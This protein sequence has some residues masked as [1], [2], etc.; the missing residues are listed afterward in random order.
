[1]TDQSGRQE[2][3]AEQVSRSTVPKLLLPERFLLVSNRLPYRIHAD[4]DRVILQ[5][6]MGGL[7]TALDPVMRQVGGIWF[8]WSGSY[9]P[10]SARIPVDES[11]SG[12]RSYELCPLNLS[13][14][15]ISKYY[16]GH[17]NKCI[18]PLFHYFQEHCEY[19]DDNWKMYRNVNLKFAKKVIEEHREG[20]FVWIHDYQLL[21]VPQMIRREIPDAR[22]GFFL[23]IPFPAPEIFKIDIHAAEILEGL[24]GADLIGFHTMGYARNFIRSVA[25]LTEHRYSF[26]DDWIQIHDRLVR[27]GGFPIS[28]DTGHFERMA[29]RPG[30]D[31][32][33]REIRESYRADVLAIGVDR[34]D[35]TKGILER[36]HA[37]EIMLDRYTDMQGNFT[38]IQISAPS[39]TEVDAYREMRE[40]IEQMV[41]RINGRFGAKGCIPIDYRYEGH[42]QEELVAYYR[43]ADVALVTPLRD[44]MNLVAKEYIVSKLDDNGCLVLSRFTGA[45]EELSDAILVNPYHPQDMADAI[46]RSVTLPAE[47]K[48]R[49]FR[50]MRDVVNRNDIYWWMERFL[51]EQREAVRKR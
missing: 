24:L 41:G 15:E 12:P 38:Y 48:R 22:I 16:L 11:I 18:W 40:R 8:G 43:A 13:E 26:Q 37:I 9:S 28:I 45:S 50:H 27:V 29:S 5:R 4:G 14:E 17:A 3:D 19:N 6:S 21:L 49:R 46:H 44:G 39:R 32:R 25:D 31:E 35:Y 10:V 47:E 30:I 1:M 51:R 20:D 36:L 34:L 7:V 23:H 33:I 2:P 42:P